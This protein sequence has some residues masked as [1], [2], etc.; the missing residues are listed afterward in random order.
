MLQSS[1]SSVKVVASRQ[2]YL[3]TL[4]PPVQAGWPAMPLRVEVLVEVQVGKGGG[5][6]EQL[7]ELLQGMLSL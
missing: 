2:L 4:A 5:R 6:E 1:G 3:L 7:Q